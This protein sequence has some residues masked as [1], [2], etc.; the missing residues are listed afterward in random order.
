GLRRQADHLGELRKARRGQIALAIVAFQIHQRANFSAMPVEIA[1]H[2]GDNPDEAAARERGQRSDESGALWLKPLEGEHLFELI[3][4]EK[5]PSARRGAK[6]LF[7][8]LC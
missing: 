3:E 6:S 5:Q 2:G 1:A 4:E 7:A 8:G